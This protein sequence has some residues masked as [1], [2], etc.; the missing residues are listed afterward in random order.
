M[1]QSMEDTGEGTQNS[2][3]TNRGSSP[4]GFPAPER[5]SKQSKVRAPA[6][7]HNEHLGMPGEENLST[8]VDFPPIDQNPSQATPH[9]VGN[10]GRK[11]PALK[12]RALCLPK[13]PR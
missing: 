13:L 4:Q 5:L 12:T 11:R 3:S 6:G 7:S 9:E 8:K 10:P 1:F 2:F